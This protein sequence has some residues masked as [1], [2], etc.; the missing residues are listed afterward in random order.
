MILKLTDFSF[1]FWGILDL[2]YLN[3]CC[4]LNIDKFEKLFILK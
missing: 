1:K 2:I 3:F 4:I